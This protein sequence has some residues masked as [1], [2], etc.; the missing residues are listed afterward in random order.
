MILS[1]NLE[2]FSEF[3]ELILAVKSSPNYDSIK[4]IIDYCDEH[5]KKIK[6][7]GKCL[8]KYTYLKICRDKFRDSNSIIL[9]KYDDETDFE[10]M[11]LSQTD[12]KKYEF[13]VYES[14]YPMIQNDWIARQF[15]IIYKI[16]Q[17]LYEELRG[18]IQD[19]NQ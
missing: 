17:E 2:I 18:I 6:P 3:A 19:D 10:Y 8:R 13:R 15:Y 11:Y 5:Y 4:R 9:Q 1:D 7:T 16:P 14:L 12:D